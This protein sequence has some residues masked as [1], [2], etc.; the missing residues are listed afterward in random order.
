DLEYFISMLMPLLMFF[1]PVMY[2]SNALPGFI[3]KFMWVNPL[4][5][6]IEIVRFPL[7]NEST[8]LYLIAINVGMLVVGGTMTLMLFN[9][10]RNRIAFWV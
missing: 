6:M 1:S 3:G 7:L 8:P 4:A 5:D 10:K 9:A 2:R